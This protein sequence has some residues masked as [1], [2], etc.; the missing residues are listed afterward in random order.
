MAEKA[1]TENCIPF[2]FIKAV[3]YIFSPTTSFLFS[4]LSLPHLRASFS[5]CNSNFM[6]NAGK[7]QRTNEFWE[8]EKKDIYA[9]CPIL[10]SCSIPSTLNSIPLLANWKILLQKE[11]IS[12]H[13]MFNISFLIKMYLFPSFYFLKNSHI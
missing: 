6:P 10:I 12:F 5:P 13:V 9:L 3:D 8:G 2:N 11:L 1:Y 7:T 4:L